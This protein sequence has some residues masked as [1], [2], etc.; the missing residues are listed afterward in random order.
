[1]TLNILGCGR[2]SNCPQCKILWSA[3]LITLLFRGERE[4]SGF[5][6]ELP[7]EGE[8]LQRGW[9]SEAWAAA[10]A[11]AGICSAVSG[12]LWLHSC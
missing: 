7:P 3:F 12:D 2:E 5:P 4:L 9:Y 8:R 10:V 11:C 1:M 6:K